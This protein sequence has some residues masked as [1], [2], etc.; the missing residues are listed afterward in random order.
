MGGFTMN[1]NR[2]HYYSYRKNNDNKK[3]TIKCVAKSGFY[4]PLEGAKLYITDRPSHFNGRRTTYSLTTSGKNISSIYTD[5]INYNFGYGDY[6]GD[7]FLFVFEH[8]NKING[9]LDQKFFMEIIVFEG[10]G[11]AKG[12]LYRML[13]CGELDKM[14]SLLRKQAQSKF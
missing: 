7:A 11:N 10:M 2:I 5:D 9:Y 6:K 1:R 14:I 3:T 13:K 4:L 8:L 12:E